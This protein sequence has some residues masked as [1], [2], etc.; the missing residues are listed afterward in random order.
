MMSGFYKI[1]ANVTRQKTSPAPFMQV[2]LRKFFIMTSQ[3]SKDLNFQRCCIPPKG[4]IK[5]RLA[6]TII[7]KVITTLNSKNLVTSKKP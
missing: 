7:Q 6:S 5:H 3:P 4:F 1:T 2:S